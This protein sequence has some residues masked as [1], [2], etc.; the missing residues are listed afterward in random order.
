MGKVEYLLEGRKQINTEYGRTLPV[1]VHY[2]R[3]YL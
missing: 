1:D 3:I 2:T